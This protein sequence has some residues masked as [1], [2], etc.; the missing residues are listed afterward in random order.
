MVALELDSEDEVLRVIVRDTGIGIP[1]EYLDRI[2]DPFIQVD[3]SETR[4]QSGTGLGLT[5]TRELARLLGGTVTVESAQGAGSTF[6]VEL[7][8]DPG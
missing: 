4:T 3:A 1:P 8:A 7:P 2:F 6:T 5:I